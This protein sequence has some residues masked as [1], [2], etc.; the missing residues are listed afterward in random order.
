MMFARVS[1]ASVLA[2]T[3]IFATRVADHFRRQGW[4]ID[5]LDEG[6]DL[7]QA[8][9]SLKAN[10]VVMD[11]ST[12]TESGFL[13]CAKLLRSQPRLQVILVGSRRRISDT[14]FA[15][16]VGAK[17]YV[18]DDDSPSFVLGAISNVLRVA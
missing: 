4:Q 9:R 1:N 12:G 18:C 11:I 13:T 5:T 14:K 10:A 16:F 6:E 7:N 15:E 17:G 8:V 3:S 2:G